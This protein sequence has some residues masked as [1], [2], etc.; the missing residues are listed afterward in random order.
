MD[1]ERPRRRRAKPPG[2]AHSSTPPVRAG[3]PGGHYRPLTEAQVRKVIEAAYQVLERTGIEVMASPS[4]EV[5]ARAGCRIDVDRNRVHIPA[6][7]IDAARA[8]ARPEVLLAA[9]DA[10]A[11]DLHLGGPRVYLGT[12]GQ[13]VKVMDLDGRVRESRLSDNYHIG[14]LCD[15][16]EHIHFCLLY[17]SPSPRD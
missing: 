15:A 12:G 8:S 3:L 5:F 2:D 4:R 14:R 13:A 10:S 7:L 9:R 6:R 17:T 1:S 16:L 11:P